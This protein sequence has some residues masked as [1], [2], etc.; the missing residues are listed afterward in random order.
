M[1][2]TMRGTTRRWAGMR[3]LTIGG[4]GAALAAAAAVPA[5]AQTRDGCRVTT[6]TDP[7]RDVLD[8]PGGV[9]VTAEKGAA[10]RLIDANRDGRPEAVELDGKALLIEVA[11][12]RSGFQIRTPHAVASVRG[13]IWAVEA[14][15]AATAVFVEEGAVQVVRRGEPASVT[16]RA[17]DGVDVA[18]GGGALDVKRWSRERRL[19]LLARFG[20]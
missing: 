9:S 12:R 2:K 8:C 14:G 5:A 4:L 10:Y 3:V 20:R 16:L 15:A 6:F 1:R 17:G 18:A 13:T 7:P 19:H 11:P